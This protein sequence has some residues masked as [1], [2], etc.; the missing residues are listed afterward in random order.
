[1][2]TQASASPH[3]TAPNTARREKARTDQQDVVLL[4]AQF[5]LFL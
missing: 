2:N 5:R 1:M 4:L 3:D